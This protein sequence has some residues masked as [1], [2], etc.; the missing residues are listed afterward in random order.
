MKV[1][2]NH[3]GRVAGVF[4][5]AIHTVNVERALVTF[6]FYAL[7]ANGPISV[8]HKSDSL[9]FRA[10]QAPADVSTGLVRHRDSLWSARRPA[11]EES[12]VRPDHANNPA[13]RSADPP[14][15]QAGAGL[16]V[17]AR[18]KAI[19]FEGLGETL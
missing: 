4:Q 15:K 8:F 11:G 16:S 18:R 3:K 14:A 1:M 2:V 19:P 13:G 17:S 10:R 6:E 12:L 9:P 7:A 5:R